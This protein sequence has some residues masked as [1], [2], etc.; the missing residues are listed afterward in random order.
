MVLTALMTIAIL[1]VENW[2]IALVEGFGLKS[3]CFANAA[4][5]EMTPWL[6]QAPDSCC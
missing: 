5:S 4:N 2:A 3:R 1:T 6:T